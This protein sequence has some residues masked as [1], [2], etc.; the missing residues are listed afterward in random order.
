VSA[1]V[2]PIEG[3]DMANVEQSLSDPAP[4]TSWEV[5]Y[6][7]TFDRECPP[8]CDVRG[9]GLVRGLMELWAR[10]LLETVRRDAGVGF[11]RFQL[12]SEERGTDIDGP[13]EG[14]VRLRRW[15]FGDK[16]YSVKGY[17]A[18]AEASLLETIAVAHAVLYL[19]G[20]T[21]E[22]ILAAALASADRQQFE[23]KLAGLTPACSRRR[24]AS[25]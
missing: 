21:S 16:E 15:V 25:A 3:S 14:A 18:E 22:P 17:V 24:S 23:N 1:D 9:R 20:H 12:R 19:S 2:R 5:W 8:H 6:R 7:D 4:D 13:W 10:H 11:S